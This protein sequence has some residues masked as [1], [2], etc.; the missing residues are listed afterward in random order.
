VTADE[1][2][3]RLDALQTEV[4]EL[5]GG[6][7]HWWRR[8]ADSIF[9]VDWRWTTK[10]SDNQHNSSD[11]EFPFTPRGDA[12]MSQSYMFAMIGVYTRAHI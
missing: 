7:N 9:D 4:K 11:C 12:H 10:E 5:W 6:D 2:H 8:V 3:G 1:L